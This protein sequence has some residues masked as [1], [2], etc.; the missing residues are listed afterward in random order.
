MLNVINFR[1]YVM[2]SYALIAALAVTLS[3]PASAEVFKGTFSGLNFGFLN[4]KTKVTAVTDSSSSTEKTFNAKQ[5]TVGLQAGYATTLTNNMY[6]AADLNVNL[7]FMG[8]KRRAWT[9][10]SSST[11]RNAHITA[12]RDYEVSLGGRV[13]YNFDD[14]VVYAG[15][16][17]GFAKFSFKYTDQNENKSKDTLKLTYGPLIG[18]D[19]KMT[20]KLTAGIEFRYGLTGSEK[21]KS[22]HFTNGSRKF[23][24]ATY[25]TRVR[26]NFAF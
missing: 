1:I 9:Y 2:R 19:Y 17:L 21:I 15:P 12:T 25:D 4:T 6:V 16:Y 8:T 14:F 3:T 18:G 11:V 13:G 7:D 20:D 24:P 22:T 5:M 23:K 10:N 26:L